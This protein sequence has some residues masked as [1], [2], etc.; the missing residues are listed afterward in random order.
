ML[1]LVLLIVAILMG[2]RWYLIVVLRF[3]CLWLVILGIFSYAVGS[4]YVFFGPLFIKIFCPFFFFGLF[5]LLLSCRSSLYI[6]DI[7]PLL[8]LW[9]TSIFFHYAACLF[10]LLIVS[11]YEQIFI[12]YNSI[13]LFLLLLPV[14]LMSYLRNRYQTQSP[15]VFPLSSSNSF[16]V[17]GLIL[18][19]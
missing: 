13:C 12:W 5:L 17:V 16:I 1:F 2:V 11:L 7:N 4:L 3:S 15:K 6:S 14:L 10:T 19:L 8:N 18:G 9:F